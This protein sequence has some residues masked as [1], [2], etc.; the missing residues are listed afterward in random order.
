VAGEVGR[1]ISEVGARV[2]TNIEETWTFY[3][4]PVAHHK[5][6]KSTNLL[7]QFNHEIKRRTLVVR[8]FPD[9]ASSLRLIRAVAS[10]QHEEWMEGSHY[11]HADLLREQIKPMKT[12]M[13]TA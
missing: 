13:M 4:L 12:L 5:H 7:E 3:R 2:V 11:P 10:E 9:V 6:L 8:I 1:K